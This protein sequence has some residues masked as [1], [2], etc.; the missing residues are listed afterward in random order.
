LIKYS[1]QEVASGKNSLQSCCRTSNTVVLELGGKSRP[2]LPKDANLEIAA[3]RIVWGK[4][5]NAGQ[6]CVA[7]DYLLVEE[8]TGTISGNVEKIH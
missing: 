8:S 2:L 1:S 5:L 4:F 3:K 6:T 7:P